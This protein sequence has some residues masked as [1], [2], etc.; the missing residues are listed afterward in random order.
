MEED[1]SVEV[2][3]EMV[4]PEKKVIVSK[5]NEDKIIEGPSKV[6]KSKHGKG[7]IALTIDAI[8]TGV[9][10]IFEIL[11]EMPGFEYIKTMTT[12]NLITKFNNW[13]A[14]ITTVKPNL[15]GLTPEEIFELGKDSALAASNAAANGIGL[16]FSAVLEFI[17]Q[18]PTVSVL[19]ITALF[20]ILSL[21]FKFLINKL[22]EHGMK[23]HEKNMSK[24]K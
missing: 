18:H 23:K 11:R 20:G 22:A 3:D 24:V 17:V 4:A 16:V 9:V 7:K 8:C 5:V 19:G 10:A 12:G 15:E 13:I 2:L 1:K 6:V 14:S 21:P